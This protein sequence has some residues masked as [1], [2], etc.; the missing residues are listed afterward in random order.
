[1]AVKKSYV[2]D[3]ILFCFY[4]IAN[5][6]EVIESALQEHNL[7]PGKVQ[8]ICKPVEDSERCKHGMMNREVCH[9]CK[10]GKPTKDHGGSLP[11]WLKG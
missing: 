7:E 8:I 3:G 5:F 4:E 1:V 9:Y 10:G 11:A 2:K 6:D